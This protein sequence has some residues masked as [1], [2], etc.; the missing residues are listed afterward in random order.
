M[1]RIWILAIRFFLFTVSFV[2]LLSMLLCLYSFSWSCSAVSNHME[3]VCSRRRRE[4]RHRWTWRDPTWIVS[5]GRYCLT[6][7]NPAA[8][9]PDPYDPSGEELRE[10]CRTLQVDPPP[11]N[12]CPR[13]KG[14][15]GPSYSASERNYTMDVFQPQGP[16]RFRV[17]LSHARETI[18]SHYER[19]LFD[20]SGSSIV[21][22]NNPPPGTT[23]AADPRV[24]H[25]VTL[26][27]DP[28]GNMQQSVAV[29]VA[30]RYSDPALTVA[31]Q[32][33]QSTLLATYT[34]NSHQ[35]GSFRPRQLPHST[36]CRI[37]HLRVDPV[38]TEE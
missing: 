36:A 14:G 6:L 11:G 17:F 34:E 32:I 26:S 12:L 9:Q 20:V 22:A 10:A 30:A 13:W 1:K 2:V 15:V 24:T 31:D 23:T 37:A 5:P 38:R 27:V 21:D 28:Y 18:D 7:H 25:A 35:P 33:K 3:T 8:R 19:K 16:N 29:V 4:R